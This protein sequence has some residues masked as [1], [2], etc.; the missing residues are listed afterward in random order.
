M[1]ERLILEPNTDDPDG[2]YQF[3][4]DMHKDLSEEESHAANARLILIMANHIGDENIIAKAA[5]IARKNT[6]KK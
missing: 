1:T 6:L 5:A 3:I 4:I 2:V